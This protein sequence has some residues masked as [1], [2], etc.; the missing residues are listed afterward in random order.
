MA[1]IT[2]NYN[3]IQVGMGSIYLYLSSGIYRLHL[4]E[5][6]KN[7][8]IKTLLRKLSYK[9]QGAYFLM[10]RFVI[11]VWIVLIADRIFSES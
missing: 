3:T 2:R 5:I 1:A 8:D 9:C 6:A 4:M 10:F 7:N 11:H